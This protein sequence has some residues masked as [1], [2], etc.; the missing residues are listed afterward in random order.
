MRRKITLRRPLWTLLFMFL[1]AASF[2]FIQV[3]GT[4]TISPAMAG[5]L[6]LFCF[7]VAMCILAYLIGD[8]IYLSKKQSNGHTDATQSRDTSIK[9]QG[10]DSI[11]T[12]SA[13]TL[14]I[15]LIAIILSYRKEK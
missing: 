11:K 1:L 10:Y 6:G 7:I 14:L 8:A 13:I 2:F 5:G 15:S 3:S 12:I 9:Q 4:L